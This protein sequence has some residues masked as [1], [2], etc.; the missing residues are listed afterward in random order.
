MLLQ[1]ALDLVRDLACAGAQLLGITQLGQ[2]RLQVADRSADGL[3]CT[4]A[5]EF[6]I[7]G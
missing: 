3:G 2:A 1:E 5:G 4:R 6:P 7:K